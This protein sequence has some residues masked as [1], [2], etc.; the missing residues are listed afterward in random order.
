MIKIS[1]SLP[2]SVSSESNIVIFSYEKGNKP[3]GS[4]LFGTSVEK[5]FELAKQDGFYGKL[6]QVVLVRPKDQRCTRYIFVGLGSETESHLDCV[7]RGT[8]AA[9]RAVNTIGIK[10][11]H[12]RPPQ[13]GTPKEAA[14]AA[15]EGAF[16][17]LYRYTEFKSTS[18]GQPK[19]QS[20]TLIAKD[21]NDLKQFSEGLKLGEI[22]GQAVCYAR[23]LINRPPS[24]TPPSYLLQKARILAKG[25]VSLKVFDKKQLQKMGMGALN[26]AER[27]DREL[28]PFDGHFG[29]DRRMTKRPL[30]HRRDLRDASDRK[31]LER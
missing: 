14:Q 5:S 17:G 13:I 19:L 2:G 8:A 7:R 23:D 27:K 15:T 28:K 30:G 6:G 24:D 21:T 26:V 16:L 20:L 29:V 4:Y 18:E 1:T 3:I 11:I 10:S 9:V 12:L 25:P 31:V 22:F